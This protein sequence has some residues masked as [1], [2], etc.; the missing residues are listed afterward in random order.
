MCKAGCSKPE[1]GNFPRGVK[2]SVNARES[3][4]I[5]SGLRLPSPV[6]PIPSAFIQAIVVYSSKG[7]WDLRVLE[8]VLERWTPS[9]EEILWGLL[10]RESSRFKDQPQELRVLFRRVERKRSHVTAP[11]L[12]VEDAW[13]RTRTVNMCELLSWLACVRHP[14]PHSDFAM[15]S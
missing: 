5:W 4:E 11:D 14:Q 9:Q 3:G 13:R 6:H 12:L 2:L 8:N 7:L 1:N 15:R 10:P